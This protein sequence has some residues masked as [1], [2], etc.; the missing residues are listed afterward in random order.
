MPD[1]GAGTGTLTRLPQGRVGQLIA[2]I[3]IPWRTDTSVGH[4]MSAERS[5]P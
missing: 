4:V 5:T 3:G 1:L 2:E